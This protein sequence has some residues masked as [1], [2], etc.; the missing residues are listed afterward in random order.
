MK[1]DGAIATDPHAWQDPR[2]AALN[3]RAAEVARVGE[4]GTP[5]DPAARPGQVARFAPAARPGAAGGGIDHRER[6][7]LVAAASPAQRRPD[8]WRCIT[9]FDPAHRPAQSVRAR[10]GRA[11][12]RR[13][14]RSFQ[15]V[16]LGLAPCAVHRSGSTAGQPCASPPACRV[17]GPD[18]DGPDAPRRCTA[19]AR[20]AEGD[21]PPGI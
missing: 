6:R 13:P 21:T 7:E 17:M 5:V 10:P 20:R 3:I 4:A 2:N 14:A 16:A 18:A 15:A 9:H 8:G 19:F 1:E 12:R 11:R